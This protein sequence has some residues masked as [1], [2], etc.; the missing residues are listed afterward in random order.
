MAIIAKGKKFELLPAGLHMA[1]VK[2]IEDFE[3]A[4]WGERVKFTLETALTGS[5]G[6]NLSCFYECS[7]SLSPLSKLSGFVE[8]LL[9][10]EISQE[11]RDN[12]FDLEN[13]L[14]LPCQINVKHRTSQAT[15]NNY[16]YVD[17]VIPAQADKAQNISDV[18]VEFANA[19]SKEEEVPF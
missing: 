9:G 15:G 4:S 8:T 13:L 10:R 16:S 11:E 3:H 14:N 17:S 12:G 19:G 6:Q 2:S 18:N 1:F 5:E 7:L